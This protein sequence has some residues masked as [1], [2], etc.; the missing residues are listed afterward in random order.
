MKP[1]QLPG[2]IKHNDNPSTNFQQTTTLLRI[3][4]IGTG[5][6][7]TPA[8]PNYAP[9]FCPPISYNLS[10]DFISAPAIMDSLQADWSDGLIPRSFPPDGGC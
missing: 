10:S 2:H 8:N 1:D 9:S 5:G 7:W 3:A 6:L 4:V